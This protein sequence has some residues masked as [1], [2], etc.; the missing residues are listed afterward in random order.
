MLASGLDRPNE[1]FL[2][3]RLSHDSTGVVGP[4]DFGKQDPKGATGNTGGVVG[5]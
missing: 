1:K 3:M 4:G 5:V 2:Q